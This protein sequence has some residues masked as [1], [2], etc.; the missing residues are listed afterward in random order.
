MNENIYI[1]YQ[2]LKSIFCTLCIAIL[3]VYAAIAQVQTGIKGKI[4]DTY[5]DGLPGVVI[6]IK[7]SPLSVLTNKKGEYL[8]KNDPG[9]FTLTIALTGYEP[10]QRPV[11]IKQGEITVANITLEQ[12]ANEL[13]EVII[14]G[15]RSLK[16][17]GYLNDTH[18]NVIYSAQ[19]NEVVVL[20]SIDAN[21][22]QDNPR[23]T[24]GRV[25][26]SNYSETEGSG[27]PSNGIG[28]RGLNPTQSIETNTRQNGYNIAGDI[29]GY[30]ESYYL[31]PL[32]AIDRVEVIRGASAL[33]FGPQFGGVV[34]YIVKNGAEDKP[35]EFTTD[36]TAGS[37]GLINMFNSVSG[38]INKWHYY[39]FVDGEYAQ[40]WR[41]NSQLEQGTGFARLEYRPNDRFKIGIEYSMLRN[42]LHLPG[43]L[44]DAE[45]NRNPNSSY[46]ARNWLVTPWNIL[47]LTSTWKI[48]DKTT[49]SVKSAL[50]ISA[51][52]IVWRNEDGGPETL[53]SI[54]TI[55][56]AYVPREVEHEYFRN[57]TTEI[58]LLSNYKI[59]GREQTLGAG[60]RFYDGWMER[61]EGGVGST[62]IDPDFTNYGG[63]YE[64]DLKFTTLNVAPFF[65]NIFH[66]GQRLSIVPG[67]RFEYIRSTATGDVLDST[68]TYNI[69]VNESKSRFIPLAGLGL[70]YKT[71]RTTNI[72]ANLSQAYRPIEYSFLYPMGLDVDAK[73][74]PN[75]K[76]ITGYNL[77]LGWRGNIKDFL[78]FDVSGFFMAFNHTIAIETMISGANTTYFETNVGD[79]THIGLESYVELN[80][81][82]LFTANPRAGALSFFNS[83]AYD[84]AKYVSGLYKGHYTEFAPPTIERF[85]VTYAVGKISSTFLFS[86]TAKSYTDA[87]NTGFSPDAEVGVMPAYTV[88]DWSN[89]LR[90]K[91]Y[92]I[93]F[94]VNNLANEKYFTLR[95]VEYPGPGI[96]PSIGRSFYI[97]FG[98][99]F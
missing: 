83:F 65:E 81:T 71:S 56:N 10:E 31:P 34:D 1:I 53:D 64:N 12:N 72:Y 44:D 9:I 37:F 68:G 5:G 51:R 67:V 16:G 18:D 97:G 45:F 58:R 46:R 80:I 61:Q 41:K 73:I 11:T 40:G 69:N 60:L 57:S 59:G 24:L 21:T 39:A 70:Q 87:N 32:E 35:F 66:V 38:T 19:K 76:D 17:M 52:S 6:S 94:G 92:H 78:T 50:N 2:P 89:T 84:N 82:K 90:I 30:P 29:Y 77:D 85:G 15:Y 99:T 28:F 88:M 49:L 47:A 13:N 4:T 26:G 63:T 14:K 3:T 93:K 23:Q 27:F 86:N 25:P 54:S 7:D 43:G 74:D 22:A 79:A 48:S 96:I 91:N 42:L 20:D 33:Q 75:L 98:G 36:F 95:T 62:D 55:T 8:L